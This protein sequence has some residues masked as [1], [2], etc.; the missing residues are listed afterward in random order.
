MT[1]SAPL[2]GNIR[3]LPAPHSFRKEDTK[4]ERVGHG[5]GRI[6]RQRHPRLRPLLWQRRPQATVILDF[7]G[8]GGMI[9]I[10]PCGDVFCRAFGQLFDVWSYSWIAHELQVGTSLER[11]HNLVRFQI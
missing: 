10:N 6:G 1:Q 8:D 5:Q 7:E 4:V 11:R 2:T 9:T 3:Y